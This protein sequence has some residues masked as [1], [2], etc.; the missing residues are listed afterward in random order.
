[1]LNKAKQSQLTSIEPSDTYSNHIGNS[2][3]PPPI[4]HKRYTPLHRTKETN[5]KSSELFFKNIEKDVF[6]IPAVKNVQPNISKTKKY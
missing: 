6:D 1:M 3:V 2:F 5:I 4:P